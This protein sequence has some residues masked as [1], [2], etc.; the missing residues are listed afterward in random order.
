M[1]FVFMTSSIKENSK[2]ILKSIISDKLTNKEIKEICL[3]KDKQWKFGIKSQLKWFKNNIKK[4]DLH[5]FFYIK[6]KLVG[7]TLLRKRTFEIK[8]FNKKT[9]YLLFDTLVLDK[10]YRGMNFSNLL[11]SFNN[12]IIEQSGFFS[13]LIC[14]DK[15]VNFYK[16][17]NW[18]K[19]NKNFF[20]IIDYPFPVN[21]MIFNKL[22]LYKKCF[23]Y[24][25]K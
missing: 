11:M 16:K 22:N 25:N 6:S 18:K 1:L 21:G 7:Y 20:K 3:L 5:N 23:F 9:K 4:Y 17:N 19:L 8:N 15:L 24:I 10:K 2:Y 13:F 12:M 14:E